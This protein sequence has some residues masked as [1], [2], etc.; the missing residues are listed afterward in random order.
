MD[1]ILEATEVIWK[2]KNKKLESFIL[3]SE[4]VQCVYKHRKGLFSKPTEK[5]VCFNLSYVPFKRKKPLVKA[6]GKRLEIYF[7]ETK[8][9]F[10]FKRASKSDVS[11][12]ADE[13]RYAVKHLTTTHQKSVQTQGFLS[14]TI[15][16]FAEIKDEITRYAHYSP[17]IEKTEQTNT[18]SEQSD[19]VIER[20]SKYCPECGETVTAGAKFCQFCGTPLDSVQ[21]QKDLRQEDTVNTPDKSRKKE[22][23]QKQ[24][25]KQADIYKNNS[26]S[27]EE[28]TEARIWLLLLPFLILVILGIVLLCH[29]LTSYDAVKIAITRLKNIDP[30]L[31]I[32]ICMILGGICL[33][34][35]GALTTNPPVVRLFRKISCRLKRIKKDTLAL[36]GCFALL[37]CIALG[38]FTLYKVGEAKH[39]RHVDYLESL[40][41]E[42]EMLIEQEDFA[43]AKIK[44]AQ[45]Y[46]DTDWSSESEEKWDNVREMLL[47]II[48]QKEAENE[49]Q[50]EEQ[51]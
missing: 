4:E 24:K 45:I 9:C 44:A 28:A 27:G 12:W 33:V 40:V 41:V 34:G 42:V 26:G 21:E 3:T 30:M 35:L 6:K 8:E 50:L 16:A 29:Q 48:D 1:T 38:G 22:Q 37:A 11:K 25:E 15:A 47:E 49:T 23:L 32:A 31:A 7:G 19:S 20:V 51:R 17:Q 39:G 43:S 13:I 36:I 18:T 10:S 46:D 14:E 2:T 5:V